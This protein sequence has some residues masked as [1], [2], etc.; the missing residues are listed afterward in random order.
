MFYQYFIY[1]FTVY[2]HNF[3]A[4]IFILLLISQ[5]ILNHI[6]DHLAKLGW[7]KRVSSPFSHSM[8]VLHCLVLD[9]SW[10]VPFS[11]FG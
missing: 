11:I 8:P 5:L 9:L 1:N 7:S 10:L 2:W 6:H 3:F 4:V